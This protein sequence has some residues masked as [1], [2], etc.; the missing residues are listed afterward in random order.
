MKDAEV[1]SVV[2]KS[3]NWD[4]FLIKAKCLLQRS[5]IF[6]RPLQGHQIPGYPFRQ[7]L[8]ECD[9][10]GEYEIILPTGEILRATVD[11]STQYRAEGINWRLMNGKFVDRYS[12]VAWRKV[13]KNKKGAEDVTKE[14]R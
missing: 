8:P 10:F 13:I 7:D 2:E 5:Q 3:P 1:K 11:Y 12:V 6:G 14:I 4:E 9:L